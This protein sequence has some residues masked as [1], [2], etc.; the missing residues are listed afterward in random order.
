VEDEKSWMPHV[1]PR[2]SMASYM[3]DDPLSV[4]IL[5]GVPK[6]DKML[7]STNSTTY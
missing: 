7:R 2:W 6:Q 1:T 3:K 5:A 4:N